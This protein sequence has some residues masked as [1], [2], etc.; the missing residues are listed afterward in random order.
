VCSDVTEHRRRVEERTA[1][2]PGHAEPT[3]DDVISR[4]YEPL[5]L[6]PTSIRVDMVDSAADA[7]AL[8]VAALGDHSVGR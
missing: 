3:W 7:A 4:E 2:I 1:D 6:G 5:A 8:V